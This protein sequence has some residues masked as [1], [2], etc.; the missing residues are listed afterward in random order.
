T[1]VQRAPRVEGGIAVAPRSFGRFAG[2]LI[3]PDEVGGNL[4][5]IDARGRSSTVV[6][7]GLAS[8]GD[9]GIESAGF[10]PAHFGAGGAA[11]LADRGT[12]GNPHTGTDSVLMLAGEPLIGAGVRPGDLLVATEGGAD[13]IVVR[14][15]R[16]CTVRRIADGPAVAHAEG[17]IVFVRRK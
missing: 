7:S 12:P 14:C 2:Q 16:T 9:I 17:H 5:A 8:G 15:R 3:A 13:T 11:F 10:V 1:V 4:V 6:V